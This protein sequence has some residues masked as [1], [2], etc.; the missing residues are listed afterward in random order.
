MGLFD[1]DYDSSLPVQ[2]LEIDKSEPA[3]SLEEIDLEY[4]MDD[5][6]LD[7]SFGSRKTNVKVN[8]HAKW[9]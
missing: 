1:G 4:K 7:V 3:F 5:R 6:L 9:L 2:S 8:P